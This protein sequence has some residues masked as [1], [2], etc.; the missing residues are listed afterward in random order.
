MM[1]GKLFFIVIIHII[2][3]S[4]LTTFYYQASYHFWDATCRLFPLYL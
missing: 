4:Y 1:I 2:Y 3:W